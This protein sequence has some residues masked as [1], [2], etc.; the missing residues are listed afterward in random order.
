M[1]DDLIEQIAARD[2]VREE[3]SGD[4]IRARAILWRTLRT[5][6]QGPGRKPRTARRVIPAIAAGILLTAGAWWV[7]EPVEPLSGIVCYHEA[8]SSS[9]MLVVQL[10]RLLDGGPEEACRE[11]MQFAES[12]PAT[13]QREPADPGG[14]GTALTA[15]VTDHGALAVIPGRGRRPCRDLGWAPA[16]IS[17]RTLELA[18]LDGLLV[19]G[20]DHL[21]G[22]P[23]E[24]DAVTHAEAVLD[25]LELRDWR[26]EL[27]ERQTSRGACH[28]FHVDPGAKTVYID[29]FPE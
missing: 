8:S 20:R 28:G 19:A 9:N 17:E 1:N 2:P 11:A 29:R 23:E 18:R 13:G 3:P 15:C 21:G 6:P 25:Q 22:C 27:M 5:P 24:G 14:D 4:S 10:S 26:V 12:R 7:A 16:N